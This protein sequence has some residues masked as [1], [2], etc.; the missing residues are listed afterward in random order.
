MDNVQRIMVKKLSNF[1]KIEHYLAVIKNIGFDQWQRQSDVSYLNK[2]I[3]KE[4]SNE[5]FT[6]K[7]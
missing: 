3:I 2:L 5:G 1:K 4:L 6:K 7:R